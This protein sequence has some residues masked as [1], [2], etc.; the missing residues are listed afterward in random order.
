MTPRTFDGA[1]FV[2]PMTIEAQPVSHF[3]G[4]G[5]FFVASP[6]TGAAGHERGMGFVRKTQ[7]FVFRHSG[8]R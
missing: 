6:M 4:K 2:L 7:F 1:F 5:C 3:P 8:L